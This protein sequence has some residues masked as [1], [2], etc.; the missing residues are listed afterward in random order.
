MQQKELKSKCKTLDY[1]PQILELQ[2]PDFQ[3]FLLR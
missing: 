1:Q 2:Q 3:A